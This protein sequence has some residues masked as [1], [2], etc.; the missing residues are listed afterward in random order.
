MDCVG[1]TECFHGANVVFSSACVNE[2]EGGQLVVECTQ[3]QVDLKRFDKV[4]GTRQYVVDGPRVNRLATVPN[5]KERFVLESTSP[6]RRKVVRVRKG[7]DPK[8]ELWLEIWDERGIVQAHKVTVTKKIYGDSVFGGF[9]WDQSETKLCFVGEELL[10]KTYH[11]FF[12]PPKKSDKDG[13]VWYDEKFEYKEQFGEGLL[14]KG[15]PILFVYDLDG[16]KIQKVL[17]IPEEIHPQCPIFDA[18]GEG[19]VFSG[20]KTTLQRKLGVYACLNRPQGIYYAKNIYFDDDKEEDN[21]FSISCLTDNLFFAQFP[22]SSHDYSRLVFLGREEQFLHHATNYELFSFE[23]DSAGDLVNQRR[24]VDI[25]KGYP[26]PDAEFAGLYGYHHMYQDYGF[27]GTSN[28]F[29]L[30]QSVVNGRQRVY[31]VDIQ[32]QN[33]TRWIHQQE[34]QDGSEHYQILDLWKSVAVIRCCH[35]SRPAK[36][37]LVTFDDGSDRWLLLDEVKIKKP[38]VKAV[39]DSIKEETIVLDNGAVAYLYFTPCEKPSPLVVIAHGGPFA[40]CYRD[41]FALLRTTM[42]LQGY[43]VLLLNYRGSIGYG[44][45]FMDSLLGH[46]GERDVEDCGNL[47]R[48]AIQRYP[49]V[50]DPANVGVYGGSHGGFLTAWLIGH[51]EFRNL[52]SCAALWNPVINMSYMM[53]STDIPDWIVACCQ[54]KSLDTFHYASEDNQTFFERSPMSVVENVTCPSLL[55]I[56]TKDLRVPPHQSVYYFHALQEKGTPAKMFLYPD[57]GHSL[58]PV[59]HNVDANLNILFWFKKYF[60]S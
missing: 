10:P 2:S 8:D 54:S 58:S 7:G 56:G 5:G 17:G 52:F 28:R 20:L 51:K 42:I 11:N 59:E 29:C 31:V 13:G 55:I 4:A 34:N 53:Q 47:T 27:I 25:V 41:D 44:Q 6:S 16:D 19:V 40:C 30:L 39:L 33:K 43:A 21:C 18:T 57:S 38:A 37:F 14:E 1:A 36:L 3:E 46:I 35:F 9:A 60:T 49:K 45:D 48:L 15:N 24:I 32:G 12:D 22:R 23:V 50:V 26:K